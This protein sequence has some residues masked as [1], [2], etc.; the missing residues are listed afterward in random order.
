MTWRILPNGETKI[1]VSSF[2]SKMEGELRGGANPAAQ[3]Q[4]LATLR[5]W[6]QDNTLDEGS[7]TKARALLRLWNNSASTSQCAVLVPSPPEAQ[8]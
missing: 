5:R 4:I 3:A 7:R 8:Q 1:D 2:I 6:E